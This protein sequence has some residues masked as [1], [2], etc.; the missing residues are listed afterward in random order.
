MKNVFR[1]FFIWA[2]W[3]FFLPCT[4]AQEL[5]AS[6]SISTEQLQ[7]NQQRNNAQIYSELQ[8]VMQDFL[9]G[10]R[11]SN[12]V[13]REEEKIKVNLQLILT[14]A[15]S[16]GDFE[17][18]ARLQ[19]LRPVHGSTY[20]TVI[21][22]LVDRNFNFKYIQGS[23][24]NYND[25]NF[26]DN[27]SSMLA[28]YANLSLAISYDSFGLYGG[29]FFVQKLNNLTNI[30]QNAGTA[31][32]SVADI[33][34]RVSIAENLINQQL[35]GIREINYQY[36]RLALDTFKDRPDAARK[37]ILGLLSQMRQLNALRPGAAMIRLF[38]ESK[39]DEILQLMDEAEAPERQQAFALLGYLDPTRTESYR[40]LLR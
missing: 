2:L 34:S 5:Q 22:N 1:Y 38:F 37:K 3:A 19:V 32:G 13:F 17:A 36:H 30:A 27:L 16:L 21:L 6:V 24:L 23:P 7:L 9:N 26:F 14:K 15:S 20:E 40:R 28:Y 39:G 29:N 11:W 18:N 8:R 35:Q 31:W 25:N 10:R 4:H 33:R 12:D